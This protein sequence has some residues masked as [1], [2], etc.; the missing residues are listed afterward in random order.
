MWHGVTIQQPPR[1]HA[2]VLAADPWWLEDSI[3]S[4]YDL[5]DRIVVSYDADGRSWTGTPL[6]IADCLERI[7]AIDLEGKCDYR[8]GNFCHL[9]RSPLDN[10]TQQRGVALAQASKGAD[11]VLQLDT[12]EVVLDKAEL[13]AAILEAD[14]RGAAGVE[15]PSRYLYTRAANGV[16]LEF[17]RPGWRVMA[18]YP[19]P[20]A[21][22]AGTPL[23]HA[24][25]IDGGLY[26]ADFA[27]NNTD[28]RHPFDAVVHRVI[29]RDQAILHYYWVRSEEDM[30]RKTGWSG[31][32]DTY[33]EPRQ[34]Q[35]WRRLTRH[36]LISA[37]WPRSGPNGEWFRLTRL[38]PQMTYWRGEA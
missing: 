10:D 5:V 29:E 22:R 14:R 36:P 34:M 20:I 37:A 31:H 11:W 21:V 7:R 6:P 9:E 12:D 4:Y 35:A 19:G 26:R 28:P 17:A 23:R 27:A 2:Y 24:R 30:L 13:H 15:Y 3:L 33:S 18:N 38:A 16:F 32:T 8:P 25:Q 1:L